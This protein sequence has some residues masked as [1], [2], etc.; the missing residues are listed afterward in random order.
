MKDIAYDIVLWIFASPILLVQ[1]LA[2]L[3]RSIPYWKTAY[4]AEILCTNCGSAI[5]LVGIWQCSCGSTCRGHLLRPCVICGSLPR[6]A[7][8][9]QCHVTAKLPEPPP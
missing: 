3:A 7:R 2:R 6:V 9:Y 4:A 1:G 5:S 8:C